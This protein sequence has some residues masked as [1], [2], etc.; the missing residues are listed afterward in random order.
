[1]SAAYELQGDT[2]HAI[3]AQA[4][5]RAAEL[6]YAAALDRLKAAQAVAYQL[7]KEGKLDRSGHIE[8]S[9]VDA[10]L[11]ELERLRREQMLER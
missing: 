2:L 6:D 11:R 5:A 10:R 9:I 7:G 8:A 3:R 4:E 1:L